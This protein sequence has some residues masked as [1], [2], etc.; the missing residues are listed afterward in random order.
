MSSTEKDHR[1]W[2]APMVVCEVPTWLVGAGS[3]YECDDNID[4]NAAGPKNG[5]WHI[6]VR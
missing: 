4:R 1:L 3:R 5:Y 6:Y 2:Y